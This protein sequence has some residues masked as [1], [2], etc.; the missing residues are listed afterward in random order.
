MSPWGRRLLWFVPV[1]RVSPERTAGF[2]SAQAESIPSRTLCRRLRKGFGTFPKTKP[3]NKNALPLVGLY[4]MNAVKKLAIVLS[5]GALSGIASAATSVNAYVA[6]YAGKSDLPVP[7]KVVAP[8][9]TSP[10][11]AEVVLEFVID[12]TGVP[13][14]IEV[15]SSN[16]QELAEAAIN[17][18]RQWR[19]SPLV[20]HGE[21]VD[22]KVKLPFRAAISAI[23][24]NRFAVNY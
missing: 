20:R 12:K 19:F 4:K 14:G 22:A 7:V 13:I 3:E 17:A 24:R 15:A 2:G 10:L 6:S 16:D 8:D 1:L 18:V 11:G 21:A 5:M 23:E 9:I